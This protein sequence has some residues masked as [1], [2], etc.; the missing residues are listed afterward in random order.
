MK[1]N[2]SFIVISLVVSVATSCITTNAVAQISVGI[3]VSVGPPALPVYIQPFCPNDGYLWT[4]GYWAYGDEGYFWVSGVWVRP[5]YV[6]FLWTPG[7]W[8]YND[9]G[10]GYHGGYWGRHIGFYGGINYGYGYGGSGYTGGQWQGN[11][12]SYNTAVTNVNTTVVNNTYIN[13]TVVNNTTINNRTSFNGRGGVQAQPGQQDR[14]AMNEKH[15]QPTTEQVSHQGI[16]SH[17]RNQFAS[18]N[19][20][21]PA[22]SAM[23]MVNVNKNNSAGQKIAPLAI[24]GSNNSSRPNNTPV[25]NAQNVN[26]TNNISRSLTN[27]NQ[28]PLSNSA[29]EHSKQRAQHV[30]Q[31]FTNQSQYR[32]IYPQQH[33]NQSQYHNN[34]PQQHISQ[35]QYHNNTQQQYASAS[36]SH[37]NPMQQPH[38][39]PQQ[40]PNAALRQGHENH[41]QHYR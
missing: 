5:P 12:F 4:P 37:N 24:N 40:Q 32:N 26:Q 33:I 16:A 38:F 29:Q 6:G 36:H 15:V 13:K 18:V 8:G 27:A 21:S 17:D 10:Y 39:Q 31:Q 11:S 3:S 1:N 22:T 35:S 7:Y 14:V 20:G 19:H 30:L 23:N 2:I 28:I 9:G 34:S 41:D 25:N